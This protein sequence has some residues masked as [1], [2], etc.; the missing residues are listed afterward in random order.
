VSSFEWVKVQKK[1]VKKGKIEVVEN[2]TF[3]TGETER[4]G[5]AAEAERG[6]NAGDGGEGEILAVS[7]S[8]SQE[9]VSRSSGDP[10]A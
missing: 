5:A 10:A 7:S 9:L 4:D 1:L 3:M 6:V 2:P 8:S